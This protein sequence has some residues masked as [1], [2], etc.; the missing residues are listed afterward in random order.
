MRS[1]TPADSFVFFTTSTDLLSI[2]YLFLLLFLVCWSISPTLLR[3]TLSNQIQSDII[4]P[5][6]LAVARYQTCSGCKW[7]MCLMLC[8]K[9][10]PAHSFFAATLVCL[11]WLFLHTFLAGFLPIFDGAIIHKS[12]VFVLC[13]E[14][15][16][17]PRRRKT[18]CSFHD[19][20]VWILLIS[21]LDS[22]SNSSHLQQ[23]LAALQWHRW[24]RYWII[25][26]IFFT[27][28][29]SCCRLLGGFW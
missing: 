12:N 7:W 16:F 27:F 22:K 21:V 8:I 25:L 24:Y 15:L 13:T 19:I 6:I 17:S 20:V 10:F 26:F 1:L 3:A 2:P 29:A 14:V 28:F 5:V 18:S 11:W 23:R 4:H 9:K